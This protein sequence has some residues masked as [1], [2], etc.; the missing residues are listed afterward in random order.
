MMYLLKDDNNLAVRGV[1]YEQQVQ[2]VNYLDAN[3][4]EKIIKKQWK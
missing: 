4:V 2:N 3:L 1:F